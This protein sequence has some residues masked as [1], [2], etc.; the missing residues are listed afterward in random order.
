M[1]Q[2]MLLQCCCCVRNYSGDI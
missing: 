1:V 2:A